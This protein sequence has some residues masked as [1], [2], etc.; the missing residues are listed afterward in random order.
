MWWRPGIKKTGTCGG[1]R[2]GEFL[3]QVHVCRYKKPFT[4]CLVYVTRGSDKQIKI[5]DR[6]CSFL[7]FSKDSVFL[8]WRADNFL[9]VIKD[10]RKRPLWNYMA[11]FEDAD[12][13]SYEVIRFMKM[14]IGIPMSSYG[15]SSYWL[16]WSGS[17]WIY[18]IRELIFQLDNCSFN[19]MLGL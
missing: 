7:L 13:D 16:W 4:H 14:M 17:L 2:S 11:S 1:T 5:T 9:S 3:E 6:Q 10:S 19:L 8:N 15:F 18:M 12:Q